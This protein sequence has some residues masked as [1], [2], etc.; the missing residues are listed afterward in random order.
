[1]IKAGRTSKKIKEQYEW[2]DEMVEKL[3]AFR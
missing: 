2:K 1:M 3:I